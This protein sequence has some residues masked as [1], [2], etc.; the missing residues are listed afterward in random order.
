VIQAV[1]SGIQLVGNANAHLSHPRRERVVSDFN[2]SLLPIVGD[3]SNFKDAAPLLFGTEFAKKGKEMVDQ[4]KVMWS[5]FPKNLERKSPFFEEAPWQP[6]SAASTEGAELLGKGA[7]VEVH[8]PRGGFYSILFL[9]SKKGEG[10]RPVINLK[11]LNS[12][13]QTVH[14]KMEG[15]HTLRD[16]EDWL[17]KVDLKDAYFAIPIH[18]SHHKYIY[19]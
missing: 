9:V 4:V 12:F 10:Q 3:D 19:T 13:V 7:I 18:T 11:A 8:N 16:P 1:R 6:G 15:I 17:A 14:F 5:S 2:K